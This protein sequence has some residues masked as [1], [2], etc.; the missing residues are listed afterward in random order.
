MTC[1][2]FLGIAEAMFGP[3]VPL[4]LSFF[5]PRERVGFRHGIFIS[6]AAAAN[7]YGSA[8]A[9][10]I[11]QINGKLAP[12]QILFLIEGLPTCLLAI[13]VWF[14]LPDSIEKARFLSPR[15]KDIALT[16]V[17]RN[18]KHDVVDDTQPTGVRFR[19]LFSALKDPKSKLTENVL[20]LLL[21][22]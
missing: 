6:G 16:F 2:F 1:R 9:Y 20:T 22:R 13:V 10:G 4:Y 14:Y 17:S 8:L 15:E 19:E 21:F 18:Q 12:W 7:A 5:Y 3:G 11:S